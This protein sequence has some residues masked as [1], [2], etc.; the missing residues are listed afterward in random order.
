VADPDRPIL[1]VE[2]DD[3][4]RAFLATFLRAEGYSVTTAAN[5]EEALAVALQQH[6]R[7][8]LLD[9][10]MPGMDGFAFRGAQLRSPEV[11]NIPV[12]LISGLDDDAQIARRIGPM[13]EVP[14]P[15]NTDKLLEQVALF[16]ER[17]STPK[18]ER[19]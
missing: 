16:C 11:A 15:I 19:R 8:I 5:G 10:M 18:Q 6:P 12:I 14:K 3:D 7:L 2:D 13:A 17:V 4:S 9:L 1:I